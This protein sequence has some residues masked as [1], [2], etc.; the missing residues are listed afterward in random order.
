MASE[1]PKT[2][3]TLTETALKELGVPALYELMGGDK[4]VNE[5]REKFPEEFDAALKEHEVDATT[6]KAQADIASL[7]IDLRIILLFKAYFAD[8]F[9]GDSKAVEQ[10]SEPTLPDELK[11]K[12]K[13][14]TFADFKAYH[15][16]KMTQGIKFLE[17]SAH[18][19]TDKKLFDGFDTLASMT[20]DKPGEV[21]KWP[22]F[23][24]YAPGTRVVLGEKGKDEVS[25]LSGWATPFF[26]KAGVKLTIVAEGEPTGEAASDEIQV[27]AMKEE[28]PLKKENVLLCQKLWKDQDTPAQFSCC[29][30]TLAAVQVLEGKTPEDACK[31]VG[32]EAPTADFLKELEGFVPEKSDAEADADDEEEDE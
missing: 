27:V 10:M 3:P 29:P 9:G 8:F 2:E 17:G 13:E 7:Q 11:A 5:Y 6:I 28:S 24:P 15:E 21:E 12:M 23:F 19:I 1:T 4:K 16:S 25:K 18:A 30:N 14:F 31:M 32:I 26:E 20:L 22:E